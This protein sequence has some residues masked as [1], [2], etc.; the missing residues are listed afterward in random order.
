MKLAN[1]MDVE[2]LVDY[3]Y[4]LRGLQTDPAMPLRCFEEASL[5]YECKKSKL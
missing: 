4:E 1:D 5:C 3:Y 2:E